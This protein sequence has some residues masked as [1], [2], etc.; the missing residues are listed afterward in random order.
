VDTAARI[1]RKKTGV[2]PPVIT[3]CERHPLCAD[4]FQEDDIQAFKNSTLV[5]AVATTPL[6]INR[7][8]GPICFL[9][10]DEPFIRWLFGSKAKHDSAVTVSP[11]T[12]SFIAATGSKNIVLFGQDLCMDG[13]NTH[14]DSDHVIKMNGRTE[15]EICADEGSWHDCIS[16]DGRTK[17]TYHVWDSMVGQID[18]VKN[19]HKLE[20]FVIGGGCRRLPGIEG[21]PF[22]DALI[23]QN[24]QGFKWK[25]SWLSWNYTREKMQKMLKSLE[26]ATK[27]GHSKELASNLEIFTMPDAGWII[28]TLMYKE[29]IELENAY[30]TGCRS[31][32]EAY[33]AWKKTRDDAVNF[34]RISLTHALRA[35]DSTDHSANDRG[36]TRAESTPEI[37]L[38][39]PPS[40][41][42]EGLSDLR[43]PL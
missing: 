19:A 14:A 13:T 7:W 25:K 15:E 38:A 32:D 35:D 11:F 34:L 3:S 20:L 40:V 16:Y 36:Q 8:E 43:A 18:F 26:N 31:F 39:N 23:E 21:G 9:P 2:I 37:R 6:T 42:T 10:R 28:V 5:C 30:R 1:V 12:M 24:P 27:P 22:Q 17:R 29:I 41:H 4:L 33:Q